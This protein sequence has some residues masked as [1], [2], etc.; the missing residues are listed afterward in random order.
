MTDQATGL[1]TLVLTE[2]AHPGSAARPRLV[3]V[4][5]GKGGVGTTTLAV[6]L[7]VG[8]AQLG[9]RTV[10]VDA[11]PDVGH[12]ES[13]CRI[14]QRDTIADVLAGRRTVRE[15]LQA[16]P[17]GVLVLPGAWAQRGIA[18]APQPACR[19]LVEQLRALASRAEMIVIDAG[20]GLQPAAGLL[21]QAADEV[22]LVTTGQPNAIMDAYAAV[23]VH[24]RFA[25]R[26]HPWINQ[27]SGP[28]EAASVARR[29]DRCCR[30]FLGRGLAPPQTLPADAAVVDAGRSGEPY[31][32]A[33]PHCPAS[34]QT[35]HTA[36]VLARQ[37]FPGHHGG[38]PLCPSDTPIHTTNQDNSSQ[39]NLQNR[40]NPGPENA[41][42]EED[43]SLLSPC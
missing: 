37:P 4:A 13:L 12:V 9:L 16:G 22:L 35:L 18:D 28:R 7:A 21:W 19:R 43:R 11:A 33:F 29:L 30:R 2:T 10:L 42:S 17:A 6:N 36:G 1:R 25:P 3:V 20:N 26:I 38:K 8:L 24:G 41:D 34:R 27:A 39:D 23:K 40:L 14:R 31:V 5:G 32:L 15:T